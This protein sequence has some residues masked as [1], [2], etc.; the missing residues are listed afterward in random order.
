MLS[1]NAE[2]FAREHPRL[3]RTIERIV[4]WPYRIRI[5]RGER[6]RVAVLERTI[7]SL[8]AQHEHAHERDYAERA[9]V[10]NA[11]LY[12]LIFDRDFASLKKFFLSADNDWDRRF[13][14]RQMAVMLYEAS[15]DVPVLIGKDLRAMLVRLEISDEV[16]S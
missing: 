3:A 5:R 13:V 4:M 14:A 2:R 11:S 10:L 9:L 16:V 8:R 15:T 7:E 6:H 12:A 1:P